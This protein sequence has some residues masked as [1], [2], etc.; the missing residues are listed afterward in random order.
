MTQIASP[1][2][3]LNELFEYMAKFSEKLPEAGSGFMNFMGAI[4]QDGKLGSK[5][6]ELIT[7]GIAVG[8]RCVPCIYAHTKSALSLGATEEEV[9]EAASVAIAMGGGPAMAHVAE[10]MKAIEAFSE[11]S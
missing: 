2:E 9:L 10:V 8:L 5:E 4:M 6:K 3:K 1:E 7:V 11:K